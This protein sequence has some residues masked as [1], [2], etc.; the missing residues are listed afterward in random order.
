MHYC[1]ASLQD[2]DN[3]DITFLFFV[4]DLPNKII[5]ALIFNAFVMA[6]LF[7]FVSFYTFNLNM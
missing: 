3:L 6:S 2:F 1:M 4:Q 5:S 7:D